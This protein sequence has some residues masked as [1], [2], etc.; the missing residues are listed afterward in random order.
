MAD[1]LQEVT[2]RKDQAQYWSREPSSYCFVPITR[3]HE[4]YQASAHGR[5]QLQALE[6]PP[7]ELPHELDPLV[8]TAYALGPWS[9]F[10]ALLRRDL[11]LMRRNRCGLSRSSWVVERVVSG[12]WA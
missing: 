10:K 3:L 1:F 2:S 8:R 11:T 4:A 5:A 6:T 7:P 12:A 9:N